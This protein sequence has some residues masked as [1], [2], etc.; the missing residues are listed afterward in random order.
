ML[1]FSIGVCD[2][3]IIGKTWSCHSCNKSGEPQPSESNFGGLLQRPKVLIDS[4]AY[5]P[6]D[7]PAWNWCRRL[8]M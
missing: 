5:Q 2:L 1:N 3:V 4:V 6:E 7:A 8:S